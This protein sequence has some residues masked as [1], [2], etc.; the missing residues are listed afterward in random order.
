MS[1][2][3][4]NGADEIFHPRDSKRQLYRGRQRFIKEKGRFMTPYIST[5]LSLSI[6]HFSLYPFHPQFHHNFV[7]LA[8]LPPKKHLEAEKQQTH[9]RETTRKM[10]E[11]LSNLEISSQRGPLRV[12]SLKVESMSERIL[13]RAKVSCLGHRFPGKE[14]LSASSSVKT[15]ERIAEGPLSLS[16]FSLETAFRRI[17]GGKYIEKDREIRRWKFAAEN[18]L[19]R[20]SL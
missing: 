13:S 10:P 9:E 16:T 1:I 19:S 15:P 12:E 5:F 4:K 6:L 18:N 3:T 11:S 7:C 8:T 2:S 17:D 20:L 14:L